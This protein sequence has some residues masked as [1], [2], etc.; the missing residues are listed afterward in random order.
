MN[1][2][3]FMRQHRLEYPRFAADPGY[4]KTELEHL[5]AC[6]WEEKEIWEYASD[7]AE[8]AGWKA[9]DWYSPAPGAERGGDTSGQASG[10]R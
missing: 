9:P 1:K 10:A 8:D 7:L 4:D 6:G 2:A 3:E 5:I